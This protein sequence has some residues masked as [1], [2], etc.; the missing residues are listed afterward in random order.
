M[1]NKIVYAEVYEILRLMNKATVMKIPVE[2]L[3]F[4]KNNRDKNY[5]THIDPDDIFNSNNI[6]P[7]SLNLLSW[8]DMEFWADDE[9][10]KRLRK[11]YYE[12]DIINKINSIYKTNKT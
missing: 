5:E 2:V 11:I 8:L 12:K 7:E 6:Q 4:I 3:E 1:K 10:K 9:T